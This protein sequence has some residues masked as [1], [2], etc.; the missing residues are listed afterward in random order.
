MVGPAM[1][2]QTDVFHV[3]P[4]VNIDTDHRMFA[5]LL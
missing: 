1:I 3:I 4:Y 5:S 2:I